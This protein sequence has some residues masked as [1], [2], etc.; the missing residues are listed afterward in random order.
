MGDSAVFV[1][2]Y[3]SGSKKFKY[4]WKTKHTEQENECGKWTMDDEQWR[5]EDSWIG[6]DS[7]VG[8]LRICIFGALRLISE[9][10]MVQQIGRQ[11]NKP[12]LRYMAWKTRQD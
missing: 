10:P 6:S 5:S 12:P 11:S 4:R 1:A 3:H 2:E 7:A 8:G 9:R